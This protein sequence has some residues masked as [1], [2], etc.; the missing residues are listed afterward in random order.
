MVLPIKSADELY[1]AI[2]T[3]LQDINEPQT[4]A[5]LMDVP[6]VRSAALERFGADVQS[7]TNKLS[8]RL[9]FMWRRGVLDRFPAPPSRS[10]ARWAY[11]LSGTFENYDTPIKY[12]KKDVPLGDHA[13]RITEKDGEVI[14]DFQQ[15]TIS[16]RPKT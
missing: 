2:E 1:D 3:A 12:K 4:C 16:I 7:A 13:M 9:S 5:S 8:D 15:F 6:N 11:A 10:Q 14:L